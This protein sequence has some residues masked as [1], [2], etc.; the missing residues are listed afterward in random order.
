MWWASDECGACVDECGGLLDECGA[1]VDECGMWTWPVPT[2]TQDK[3]PMVEGLHCVIKRE[4][5]VFSY[6]CTIAYNLCHR[7]TPPLPL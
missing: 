4:I 1:C 3:V 7:A 2:H 6:V 5:E